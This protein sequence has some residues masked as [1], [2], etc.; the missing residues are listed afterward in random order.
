ML[1]H[2]INAKARKTYRAI[3]IWD[4]WQMKSFCQWF[5]VIWDGVAVECA[6]AQT[7]F[8]EAVID[9]K[10]VLMMTKK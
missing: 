8:E 10:I 5:F 3:L 9:E 7:C 4:T 2:A 1:R 6:D